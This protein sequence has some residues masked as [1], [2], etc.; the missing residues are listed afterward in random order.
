MIIGWLFWVVSLVPL[1]STFHPAKD[2]SKNINHMT[3]SLSS[4][5]STSSVSSRVV[6]GDVDVLLLPTCGFF[7][8]RV[9]FFF[10]SSLFWLSDCYRSFVIESIHCPTSFARLFSCLQINAK[11][12]KRKIAKK[13]SVTLAD[14]LVL[15]W[16]GFG[17]FMILLLFFV[18]FD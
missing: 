7:N 11:W 16:F 18:K 17:F 12:E 6:S 13:W 10:Y 4:I 3:S 2:R 14:C 5:C 1:S 9:G 8:D 15:F